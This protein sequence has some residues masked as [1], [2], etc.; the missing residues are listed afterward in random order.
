MKSTTLI[1]SGLLLTALSAAPLLA[2]AGA[3]MVNGVQ[4]ADVLLG[5]ELPVNPLYYDESKVTLIQPGELADSGDLNT[6][7]PP[8]A[9]GGIDNSASKG[10]SDT[11]TPVHRERPIMD[12]PVNPLF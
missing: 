8:T 7:L 12:T 1:A 3:D 9:A 11:T 5:T 10:E 2:T 4:V 6:A